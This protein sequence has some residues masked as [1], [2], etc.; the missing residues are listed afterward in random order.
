MK[1]LSKTGKQKQK[2]CFV[3]SPIGEP[4]S[5]TR[6]R[7]DQVL[8]YVVRPAVES[9]GY[10]AVRADELDKPGI[11]TSQVIQHV[12][13]APLVVAD[14][15]ERNPNLFYEL[16]IRHALR[17][18]FI[19]IIRTGEEIPFDVA[20]TRTIHV[21]H[22]DLDSVD[23]AKKSIVGQVKALNEKSNIETPFSVSMDLKFL[24]QSEKPEERSIAELVGAVGDLRSS[25]KGLQTL[26]GRS[27][28]GGIYSRLHPMKLVDGIASRSS[29]GVALL[30]IASYFRDSAPWLY[31]MSLEVYRITMRP[32]AS[33][34][35]R[36]RAVNELRQALELLVDSPMISE[37]FR[38]RQDLSPIMGGLH[39][40]LS[41]ISSA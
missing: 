1:H 14:L 31:D 30:A 26:R 12:A 10:V 11:I 39:R 13:D 23:A 28:P 36:L 6:K 7:S 29:P 38:D 2:Q 5:A 9:C 17:K 32:R 24:Q 25:V 16:A 34:A 21:D 27:G 20:N 19:Q 37:V 3:V 15:S 22:N 18:P 35:E 40:A 33:K 4:D 8:Q 41:M